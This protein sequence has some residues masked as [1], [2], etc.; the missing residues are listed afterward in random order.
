MASK[1]DGTQHG[2]ELVSTPNDGDEY[3]RHTRYGFIRGYP[4]DT[5]F[6]IAYM[7]VKPTN[8]RQGHGVEMVAAAIALAR[9]LGATTVSA[10]LYLQLMIHLL[11]VWRM[12]LT[13]QMSSLFTAHHPA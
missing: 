4:W 11:L 2:C 3:I 1:Q 13:I 12:K 6:H 10:S 5:D 9:K 7:E 8:R